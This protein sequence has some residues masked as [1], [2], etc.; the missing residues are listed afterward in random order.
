M[1]FI[2]RKLHV[3]FDKL[4]GFIVD[5]LPKSDCNFIGVNEFAVTRSPT[6]VA[7]NIKP[8][9]TPS[10]GKVRPLAKFALVPVAT[11]HGAIITVA[12][13]SNPFEFK[14]CRHLRGIRPKPGFFIQKPPI[15]RE[16]C[17]EMRRF[18]TNRHP[19]ART[20]CLL[21]A[22]GRVER[23]GK[24][25]HVLVQKFCDLSHLLSATQFHSRDFH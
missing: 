18:A 12:S 25:L 22:D 10:V 9:A 21:Q 15:G 6:T 2:H 3:G 14:R 23:Q 20:A 5:F 1:S 7:M 13:A 24:V 19:E 17:N 8:I 4:A 16:N 11:C